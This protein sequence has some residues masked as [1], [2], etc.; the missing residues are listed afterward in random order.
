MK[1]LFKERVVLISQ[2]AATLLT[3]EKL[4]GIQRNPEV[5]VPKAVKT[6]TEIVDA[7]VRQEQPKPFSP[8]S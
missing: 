7:V 2:I 6:A 3:V 8:V 5:T 1:L 4:P